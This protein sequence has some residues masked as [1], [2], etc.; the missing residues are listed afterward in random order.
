MVFYTEDL[1]T[2]IIKKPAKHFNHLK[3]ISGYA[4]AKFLKKLIIDYPSHHVTLIIGMATQGISRID[5]QEF[6]SICKNFTNI[7]VFYQIEL[8]PTHMKVYQWYL[9]DSPQLS[10]IGSA[11]FSE[12]GFFVQ[13]EI[14]APTIDNFSTL[15]EESLIRSMSCLN[16]QVDSLI[17]FYEIDEVRGLEPD[18]SVENYSTKGNT[19]S[20]KASKK[21]LVS[22]KDGIYSQSKVNLKRLLL[23]NFRLTPFNHV[24]IELMLL[25]DPHW[26]SKSLNIWTRPYNTKEDAYIDIDRTNKSGNYKFDFFPRGVHIQLI[27]DDNVQ[28][29]VQRTGEYGKDLVVVEGVNFYEYFL[30]RLDIREDRPIAY[31]D[32]L[33]YGRTNVEF[34]KVNEDQFI[35]DFS[36]E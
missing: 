16:E 14:L 15:I 36:V 8:P 23:N 27:S 10:F 5:H 19:I 31:K 4:S 21:Q 22:E 9:D 32:L 35:L 24:T 30:K 25:D 6:K 28:W 20:H 3:I 11:N 17:Q 34:Y 12:N 29:L 33:V 1:Y 7:H 2:Q 26:Q 13:K 18:E